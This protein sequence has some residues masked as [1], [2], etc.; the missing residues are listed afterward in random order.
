[1]DHQGG[2]FLL[3]NH[4]PLASCAPPSYQF[5][6]AAAKK[7]EGLCWCSELLPHPS[8]APCSLHQLGERGTTSFRDS[9][10]CSKAGASGQFF[11]LVSFPSFF[12]IFFPPQQPR[13][14]CQNV[15]STCSL[16]VMLSGFQI[17]YQCHKPMLLIHSQPTQAKFQAAFLKPDPAACLDLKPMPLSRPVCL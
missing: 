14:F 9:F 7:P 10:S 6:L 5:L 1:M 15:F 3:E 17:C 13:S 16:L 2:G 11:P 4:L 8:P 12:I